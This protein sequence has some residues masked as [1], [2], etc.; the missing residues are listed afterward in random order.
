MTLF[1]YQALDTNNNL[2]RGLLDVESAAAAYDE[3]ARRGLSDIALFSDAETSRRLHAAGAEI[4]T[5]DWQWRDPP[6]PRHRPMK[7]D[8]NIVAECRLRYWFVWL[9]PL[10]WALWNAFDG[11]PWTALDIASFVLAALMLLVFPRIAA[12]AVRKREALL[13]ACEWGAWNDVR[14]L[15]AYFRGP[16]RL[17]P[18]SPSRTAIDVGDA[19]AIAALGDLDRA[20]AFMRRHEARLSPKAHQAHLAVIHAAALDGDGVV[21]CREL[22]ARSNDAGP[23]E[24]IDHAIALAR[25]RRDADAAE[26]VLASVPWSG[27]S[28]PM[29]GRRWLAQGLIALERGDNKMAFRDLTRALRVLPY[30]DD[31]LSMLD[32]ADIALGAHCVIASVHGS[33]LYL[34]NLLFVGCAERLLGRR[35]MTLLHRLVDA[36]G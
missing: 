21:R 32:A 26:R 6:E 33:E 30:A 5:G 2:R 14:E 7:F 15:C 19:A 35:D 29:R 1:V 10:V 16:A 18:G 20:L 24:L 31:P 8:R 17:L 11:R 3:L 12:I 36:A 4:N 9:P 34:E 25:H 22:A 23:A 13:D 28:R 27:L